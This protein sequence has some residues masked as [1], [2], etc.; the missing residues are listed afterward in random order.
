MN[1]SRPPASLPTSLLREQ[2]LL[3]ASVFLA[4][5]L[6]I[7]TRPADYSAAVW[8]SNALLLGLL[9]RNPESA[10]QPTTWLYAYAAFCAA[11]AVT[12]SPWSVTLG[13]N[14]A[15]MIGV[16]FGWRYLVG[17]ATVT[18]G[19]KHQRA[20]LHL[21]V[22]SV[23]ATLGGAVPGALVSQWAFGTPV[24][25]AF[26]MWLSS[27]LFDM[28]L[29]LPLVLAAPRGWIW[30]WKPASLLRPLRRGSV[31]PLL[32]LAVSE[33]LT[34][35]VNG[36]GTLGFSV[37]ALVWCAMSYGVFPITVLSLLVSISKVIAM[38][39]GP[40]SFIPDQLSTVVSFRIGVAL[41][42]LAPLAVAVAHRLRSQALYRLQRAVNHDYLTGALSRRALMERGNRQL[43]R[44]HQ[45]GAA[46]V[47]VLLDLDHFKH[48]ND[49]FGHAQGDAVLQ[50]FAALVQR[51]LRPEDL[52]GR[53][54]GE[55]FVLVLPRATTEQATQ[56]AERL[57]GQLAEYRFVVDGSG[58][59]H[60][61]L[62]AGLRSAAPVGPEDTLER[63]LAH[64]DAA[65]YQAKSAG[66]N[67]VQR[68][69]PAMA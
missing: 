7:A 25:Q 65:L 6:G 9:L 29:I 17:H 14:M 37:P 8:F 46:A 55:E 59:L 47:V 62:S 35:A 4:S 45:Q 26:L 1:T 32:A 24:W 58:D 18:L 50:Q 40:I 60:V 33:A 38:A 5:L 15:N 69:A 52:F 28:L 54:G 49:R 56:V 27:E 64:A 44:L 12:G 23:V 39:S 34:Y 30:Q 21:C 67:R 43:Q 10:R 20:V 51:N 36:P 31:A 19:F 66:R 16:L 63:L 48:I 2:G 22:A 11:D 3:A 13:L 61:T 41:L 57:R 42:S 68:Y 53:I